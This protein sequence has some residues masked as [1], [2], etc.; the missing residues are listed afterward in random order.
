MSNSVKTIKKISPQQEM[1]CEKLENYVLVYEVFKL[2]NK[3]FV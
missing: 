3:F 2:Y 1:M